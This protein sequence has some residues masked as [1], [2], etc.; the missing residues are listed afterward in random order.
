MS[1]HKADPRCSTCKGTGSILIEVNDGGP[2]Y[3]PCECIEGVPV[4]A[5][6]ADAELLAISVHDEL[7][8]RNGWYFRSSVPVDTDM[9][10]ELLDF[11]EEE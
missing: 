8:A 1:K 9:S 5:S 3:D 10:F 6:V 11:D 4:A 7:R 2:W